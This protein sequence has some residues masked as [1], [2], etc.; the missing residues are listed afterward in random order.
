MLRCRKANAVGLGSRA[1]PVAFGLASAMLIENTPKLAPTS[2]HRLP[3][4]PSAWLS[5]PC[6]CR[7]TSNA[8]YAA[9]SWSGDKIRSVGSLCIGIGMSQ[10]LTLAALRLPPMNIST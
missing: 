7:S 2:S 1:T 9:M 6:M 5:R 3:S 8:G 10:N 4:W